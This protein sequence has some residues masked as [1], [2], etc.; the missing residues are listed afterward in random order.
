[1]P[2]LRTAGHLLTPPGTYIDGIGFPAPDEALPEI[3]AQEAQLG[4]GWVKVIGDFPGRDGWQV[5]HYRPATLAA[6]T[7][8]AHAAG[9]RIAIHC[10]LPEV[11]E[12]A[13]EAGFDSLE[14]GT[15][16]AP[17]HVPELV[18]RGIALVPTL[19]I[20]DDVHRMVER[21]GRAEALAELDA[22]YDALPSVLRLASES[23]VLILAG[24]D[25]GMG[26][27]GQISLEVARLLESGL[28]S[29]VALGAASWTARRWLGLPGIE[30]GAPADIIAFAADPRLDPATLGSPAAIVLDGRR[31][32]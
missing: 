26:P 30:P 16:L 32:R 19:I 13:I 28:P 10:N 23:G 6:A 25:A 29:D 24:T 2:R 3:V 7:R 18:R 31:L 4:G 5:A 12:A 22:A 21:L 8:R 1:M 14:H 20:R 15:G 9:A 11:I 27:H 17:S